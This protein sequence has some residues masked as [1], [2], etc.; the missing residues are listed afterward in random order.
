MILDDLWLI[1]FFLTLV[2]MCQCYAR[3]P[4]KFSTSLLL[5]PSTNSI[6]TLLCRG[7]EMET[8]HFMYLS[9]GSLRYYD[10]FLNSSNSVTKP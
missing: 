8:S 7:N 2:K 3:H 4:V 6:L 5:S 9:S 10:N 1:M